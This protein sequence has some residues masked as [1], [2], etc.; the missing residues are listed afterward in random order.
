M[1]EEEFINYIKSLGFECCLYRHTYKE[2]VIITFDN[3]YNIYNGSKWFTFLKYND[4]SQIKT[5]FKKELRKNK[6]KQLLG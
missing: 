3:Y 4:L 6:F 5:F 1:T 2:Y